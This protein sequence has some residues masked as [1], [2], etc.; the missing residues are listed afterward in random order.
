[1]EAVPLKTKIFRKIEEVPPGQWDK[2][3]SRRAG[4]LLF[5]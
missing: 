1:M 3:L 2:L 4:G 5:F